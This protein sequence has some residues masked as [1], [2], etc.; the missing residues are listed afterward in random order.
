MFIL[1]GIITSV[2]HCHKKLIRNMEIAKGV[3]ARNSLQ[4]DDM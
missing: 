3:M 2:K 1:K 4:Q